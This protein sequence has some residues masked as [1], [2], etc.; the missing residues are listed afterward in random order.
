MNIYTFRF[1]NSDYWRVVLLGV[2]C[3]IM[4]TLLYGI[5]VTLNKAFS[6][7]LQ[8]AFIIANG[9]MLAATAVINIFHKEKSLGVR[10]IRFVVT[11]ILFYFAY[12][13][14]VFFNIVLFGEFHQIFK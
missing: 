11:I 13:M 9:V 14:A 8:M 7:I 10:L 1:N 4:C 3:V 12:V 5:L 6:D 2:F